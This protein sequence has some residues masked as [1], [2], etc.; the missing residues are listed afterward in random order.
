MKNLKNIRYLTFLFLIFFLFLFISMILAMSIGSVRIDFFNVVGIFLNRL[1]LP[2]PITWLGSDEVIILQLRLPR[3]LMAVTIGAMLAVSGVA[4]QGLFRN[5]IVDPYIIGVSA[6]ASFG[7]ALTIVLGITSLLGLLTLPLI[8]FLFSL[9]SVFIVFK[10]S[11]TRYQLSVS[12]LLL[13]GIAISYFFSAFTSLIIYF[14][15]ENVHFIL[16]HLMGGLWGTTWID[17]YIVMVTMFPG[18][19]IL[20]LY[21]KDLNLMVFGDDIAKSMGVNIE[22]SKRIILVLMTLLTSIAVAFCGTIGFIGLIIP[23]AMRFLVGSDNRKLIPFSAVGGGLLLLWADVCARSIIPPLELPVGILT[24]LIGG[25]FF[26]Y[27]VIQKKKSGEL[28]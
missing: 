8:S 23:H 25:P 5:P 28:F 27:L 15:D 20:F 7:S 14:S 18:I 12:A 24:S 4:A 1:G 19:A 11:Q 21:G 6:S 10:L 22:Q 2:V 9:S 3:V 17:L 26:V 13:A 16:I